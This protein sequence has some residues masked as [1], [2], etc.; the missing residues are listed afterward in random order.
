VRE[1]TEQALAIFQ[2]NLSNDHPGSNWPRVCVLD[3]S[4]RQGWRSRKRK[5]T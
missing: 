1:A 4:R 3:E 5:E 2:L